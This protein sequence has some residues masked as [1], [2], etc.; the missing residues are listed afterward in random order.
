MEDQFSL[1]VFGNTEPLALEEI[2][3]VWLFNHAQLSPIK[4]LKYNHVF[5]SSSKAWFIILEGTPFHSRPILI[6]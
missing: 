3:E 4:F 6:V 5:F 1:V 2:S